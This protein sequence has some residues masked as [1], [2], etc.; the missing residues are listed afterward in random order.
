MIKLK[1]QPSYGCLL[2]E[3]LTKNIN[4]AFACLITMDHSRHSARRPLMTSPT[5]L[6]QPSSSLSNTSM[7]YHFL[8]M[9]YG[10]AIS[11]ISL[12]I[13]QLT[14]NIL[15]YH[16]M[17]IH[18]DPVWD[19][20]NFLTNGC[21]WAM[22]IIVLAADIISEKSVITQTKL[23]VSD[24][25][26]WQMINTITTFPKTMMGNELKLLFT[27]TTV[28]S[29]DCL[30]GLSHHLTCLMAIHQVFTYSDL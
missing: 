23:P 3:S 4:Q 20:G 28:Y 27:M 17:L 22:T 25:V 24:L 30:P 12:V 8:Y 14:L 6:E 16:L 13:I 9:L 1:N 10:Q 26:L 18:Q 2:D 5:S 29:F 21:G 15:C 11:K 19:A 7:C